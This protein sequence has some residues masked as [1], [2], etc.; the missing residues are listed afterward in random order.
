MDFL[1]FLPK[2]LYIIIVLFPL[3]ASVFFLALLLKSGLHKAQRK[4]LYYLILSIVFSAL[5]I[6]NIAAGDFAFK[7]IVGLPIYAMISFY[8]YLV[9]RKKS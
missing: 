1:N 2:E 9:L 4:P 8:G 5:W 7:Y 6:W 3:F